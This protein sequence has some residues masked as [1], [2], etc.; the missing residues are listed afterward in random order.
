[1]T[2][3]LRNLGDSF[4]ACGRNTSTALLHRKPYCNVKLDAT[5]TYSGF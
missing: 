1:M 5:I 2:A 3:S 4:N